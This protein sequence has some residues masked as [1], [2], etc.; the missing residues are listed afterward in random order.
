MIDM[1]TFLKS[2]CKFVVAPVSSAVLYVTATWV[3]K[4]WVTPA[5]DARFGPV[6]SE[7]VTAPKSGH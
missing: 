7:T 4:K 2:V 5:L 6:E 3:A 1:K